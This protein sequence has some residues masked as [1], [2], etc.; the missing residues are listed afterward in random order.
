MKLLMYGVN[1]DSVSVDEIY[2]YSLNDDMRKKH[3]QE[4]KLFSGVKEVVLLVTEN[5]N[6]YYLFVDEKE[7]KHGDLLRYF[8]DYTKKPL[9][10]IIL[11]TY[12]KFNDDVV[13]HLLN[14]SANVDTDYSAEYD[15]IE[16]LDHALVEALR[17]KSVGPVLYALFKTVLEFSITLC[18]KDS[19]EP[20]LQS[21]VYKTIRLI[22]KNFPEKE[23]K[24][25]LVVG[26]HPVVKQLMKHF[27]DETDS[28]LTIAVR[29][30]EDKSSKLEIE[31]WLKM[32]NH[33][34][35]IKNIHTVSFKDIVFRLAKADV[36]VVGPSIEHAWLSE[37]LIQEMNELRPDVKKQLVCDFSSSQ[38]ET[39]FSKYTNFEYQ[40]IYDMPSKLFSEEKQ[41]NAKVVYDELLTDYT[42]HYMDYVNQLQAQKSTAWLSA[43]RPSQFVS[44]NK[45]IS[46]RA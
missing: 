24:D 40:N 20:I 46:H 33:A 37:E 36:I 41:E 19:I 39:L 29:T 3:L 44:Y 13:K 35:R 38:D 21:N 27:I 1:R 4:I 6:E 30:E 18:E 2:K 14:V 12:S 45:K 42:T 5:R 28:S 10:E 17:E 25:Y 8:A 32:M 31:R 43:K 7:F 23:N 9:E 11:E 22:K 16:I 26:D 34:H 15:T